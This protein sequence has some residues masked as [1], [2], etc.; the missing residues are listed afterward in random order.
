MKI[1]T[2]R[3]ALPRNAAKNMDHD[4]MQADLHAQLEVLIWERLGDDVELRLTQGETN[5]IR[6]DGKFLQKP[7]EVKRIVGEALGEIMEDFD[8]SAYTL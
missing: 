3:F 5:D 2:I 6:I 4:A 1:V 7:L 8:S